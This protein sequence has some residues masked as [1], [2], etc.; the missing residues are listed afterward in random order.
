MSFDTLAAFLAEPD[1]GPAAA[2]GDPRRP[3]APYHPTLL[4]A[5]LLDMFRTM[6]LSRLLDDR[7]FM[8][9]KQ[10]Q[11]WF[12]I[13][14]AGK[15]AVQA[16]AGKA[17]RPT[18]PIWGYY[19]DRAICLQ[20]GVTPLEML[21]QA[22]AADTDPASSGRQMPAHF[23]HDGKAVVIEGSPVG[24][25][26]IPSVGLAEAIAKTSKLIGKGRYP[27][28]AV[29]YTSLGDATTAEGEVYEALRAAILNR[30]PVIVHIQDDGFGISVPLEEQVPGEDVLALFRGWPE[31]AIW[32]IDG[33]EVRE[34]YDA[35]AAAAAHCRAGRGAAM[36]RSKTLRLMSHSSTDDMRKYRIP[37]D[38]A[39]DWER[40]PIPKF[41][42][43]IV[44]YGLAS[45][46]ELQGILETTK[47]EVEAATAEALKA[48]KTEPKRF[49]AEVNGY[50]PKTAK[51]RWTHAS[52]G[53]SSASAGKVIPLADSMRLCLHELME[54]EP[55][56]VMWGEDIAD[57]SRKT[58]ER[59]P[60][61][62]GKGGVFGITEGLQRKFGS[63]RVANSPIAE[64]SIVGRAVG[65][66][67][68]GFLPVVEVQFRDYLNPAW[69]QLVDQAA[70]LRWR[71]GARFTCPMV[72]RMSYGGYL[73]G[74][75]AMWHSESAN[76]PLLN[77]PGI[78]VCVPGNARDAVALLRAAAYCG[79]VVLYMEPKALYR[80]NDE[81]FRLPKGG[82][83][84]QPYP[85]YSVVAW[86]GTAV[87]YGK[88]RDLAIVTYGNTTPLSMRAMHDLEKQGV[89]AR[90]VDLRWISPLDEKA[91]RAA[92][93]DC[94]KVLVVDED[95]RTCGAG[96]AIAD[97]I[98]R[99]RDLRKRVEV[100]RV[101][102]LDCRVSYGPVGERAV[103]PQVEDI[104]AGAHSLL[105]TR[106]TKKTTPPRRAK[107]ATR[108]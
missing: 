96:A 19:R 107:S 33:T 58:L 51:D 2:G 90:V 71:S 42:R 38:I 20:R 75:G 80:R 26:C 70:T 99:D 55:R 1:T 36:I 83:M 4:V 94:G 15:E 60:E 66:A 45:R 6:I 13:F 52:A 44:A 67:I 9:Q 102:A 106:S 46:A 69:Q 54:I 57:L 91:I 63:D 97:V 73:G 27:A 30:A 78:R 76:G 21:L 22:V 16:A 105:G 25:Q 72:I 28:D 93:D 31:L 86:P 48:P 103:L 8:L 18:D 24:F 40:D 104:I 89:R 95:R 39:R 12:S 74:A 108:K 47:R 43:Q 3:S 7:E 79:D 17:L 14:G 56:I 50:E 32:D 88:G 84:E 29:V 11:A 10:M 64:A 87:T 85:D 5:D 98:Y 92:A 37:A 100:E 59:H 61:L 35:F 23:G 53:R 62:K 81:A 41:A 49:L 77:H 65:Y 82:Y 68:Q 101:A 34:S